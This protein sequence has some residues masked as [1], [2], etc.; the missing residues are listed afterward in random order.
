MRGGR[1]RTA[2]CDQT[3]RGSI[4]SER[5]QWI[6]V[7]EVALGE[8]AELRAAYCREMGCQI[9]HDSWHARGF[10]RIYLLSLDGEVAGYGAVGGVP[11]DRRDVVKEFFLR[12]ERR[13]ATLPLFRRL[14]AASGARWIEAQTNDAA[15]AQLLYDQGEA[16]SSQTILFADARTT[17]LRVSG[18]TLRR[19]KETDRETLF[20]HTA[21]PVGEWGLERDGSIVATGGLFYHYNPP[22]G[23]L[24]MEVAPAHRRRGL[25]SY[26][27]QE[28]KRLCY[29]A[30]R[31]PAARCRE[32][33]LASRRTLERAGM[34]PCGKIVRARIV[35]AATPT[36][37]GAG[38]ARRGRTGP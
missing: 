15:L 35:A 34:T 37:A 29:G 5:Q 9:V 36:D 22:F 12:P 16:I 30:D 11:G 17:H 28:L 7:S 33:N 31:V 19:L 25:G 6:D 2:G 1:A 13:S 20:E 14:L 26:L 4:D 8:V 21:E 27:V 3:M 32:T 38:S 18:A 10:T 24:Y 23:D